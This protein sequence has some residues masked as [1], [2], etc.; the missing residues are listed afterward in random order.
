MCKLVILFVWTIIA[1]VFALPITVSHEISVVTFTLV[2]PF[3]RQY[4]TVKG[5]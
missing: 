1:Y 5:K 4:L 2:Y 3:K